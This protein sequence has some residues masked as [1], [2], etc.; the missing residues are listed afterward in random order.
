M[1][2]D[3]ASGTSTPSSSRASSVTPASP[4]TPQTPLAP[5]PSS[6]SALLPWSS[7]P[8]SRKS[9][10]TVAP[11]YT[12][13]TPSLPIDPADPLLDSSE[14]VMSQEP[15]FD[16]SV[17]PSFFPPLAPEIS[18]EVSSSSED[19]GNSEASPI[20]DIAIGSDHERDSFLA[21]PLNVRFISAMGGGKRRTDKPLKSSK[22]RRHASSGSHSKR[23]EKMYRCPV[24]L[25]LYHLGSSLMF[26][27][28]LS[29]KWLC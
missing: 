29:E 17:H 20:H 9:S 7:P 13:F 23:R 22:S 26:S 21:R 15:A 1:P 2:L 25:T 18:S 19:E 16:F 8:A 10:F 24:C 14:I 3:P 4:L 12:P 5:S 28:L 11:V 27:L 6:P